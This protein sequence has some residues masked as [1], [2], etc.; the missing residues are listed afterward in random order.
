MNDTDTF[1]IQK[2]CVVVHAGIWYEI[3]CE[4]GN[5]TPYLVEPEVDS[6]QADLKHI[7]LISL[8]LDPFVVISFV[9]SQI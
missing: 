2:K 4:N 6:L 8:Q 9:R 5:Q 7:L 1:V 3:K